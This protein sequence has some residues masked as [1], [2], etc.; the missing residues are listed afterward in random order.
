MNVLL[1]HQQF[2][3]FFCVHGFTHTVFTHTYK[4]LWRSEEV[5][6]G[7]QIPWESRVV[8]TLQR[9]VLGP[10]SDPLKWQALLTGLSPSA[11]FVMTNN[12][13]CRMPTTCSSNEQDQKLLLFS[14]TQVGRT[15]S[16][17]NLCPPSHVRG[18]CPC[19]RINYEMAEFGGLES[20]L[21][22]ELLI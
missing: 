6:E 15:L 14:S 8:V 17:I 18:L 10:N 19:H 13:V 21:F 2:D 9:R 11:L 3:F 16:V 5:C 22:S 20:N 7:H 1:R 12:T 4:C